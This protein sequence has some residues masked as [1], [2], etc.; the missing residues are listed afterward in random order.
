M[1]KVLLA[2]D[3]LT[4]VQTV[5]ELLRQEGHEVFPF[6]NGAAALEAITSHSPELVI[7]DLYLDKTKAHGLEILEK[8]RALNPP[9]TVIVI[10]PATNAAARPRRTTDLASRKSTCVASKRDSRAAV[11]SDDTR[12]LHAGQAR[13]PNLICCEHDA[14]GM[15]TVITRSG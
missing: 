1:A 14:Q 9:A 13:R 8:A 3:E 2:D 7:T 11:S 12:R 4:M 15:E 5:S 10:K 6:T